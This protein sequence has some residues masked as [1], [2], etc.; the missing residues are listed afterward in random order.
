MFES[1]T[2]KQCA[3][4]RK[5]LDLTE[6]STRSDRP[7]KPVSRCKK[8]RSA[9]S[10]ESRERNKESCKAYYYRR[11]EHSA[12]AMRESMKAHARRLRVETIIAYGSHC[13]CCGEDTFEFLAIDHINGGGAYQRNVLKRRG[14]NFYRWLKKQGFPKDEYQLLCHNCNMA[15]GFYGICPHKGQAA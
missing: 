7:G 11:R 15:K 6:F 1:P 3:Q 13:A 4:C 8:C 9:Q 5:I 12:D 10:K 2:H 14:V